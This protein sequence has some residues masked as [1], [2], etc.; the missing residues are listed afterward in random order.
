MIIQSYLLKTLSPS[1]LDTQNIK[2]PNIS[3]VLLLFQNLGIFSSEYVKLLFEIESLANE[4]VQ[5]DAGFTIKRWPILLAASK[6][7]CSQ[8][9]KVNDIKRALM[10]KAR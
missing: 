7:Q 3:S 5:E 1:Y 9:A 10:I 6:W 8:R 2:I 4:W